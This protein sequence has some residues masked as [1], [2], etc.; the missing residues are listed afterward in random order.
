MIGPTL[1]TRIA[2][3]CQSQLQ[4]MYQFRFVTLE[5][6]QAAVDRALADRAPRNGMEHFV[7][8]WVDEGVIV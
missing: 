4:G 7:R 8:T 3:A 2:M 6:V 5:Q 1:E